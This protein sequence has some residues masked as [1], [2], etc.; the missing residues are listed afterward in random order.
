MLAILAAFAF[1]LAL[2]AIA[3]RSGK[4]FRLTTTGGIAAMGGVSLLTAWW[5]TAWLADAL[6]PR[7]VL[8]LGLATA[9]IVVVGLRDLRRPL[10]PW[11]QLAGQTLAGVSAVLA[12][13]VLA[14]YVTNPL[15]G[16]LYLNQWQVAGLPIVAA[17]LT[18]LWMLLLMN[19]VNFLDGT[20]GVAAAV[21]LVGF[22]TV[23]AVSLLPQV[24]EP[25]TALPAFLAAAATLGFLFWN[26][27]PARLTLGTPGSWF[28]GFLL[29]V[30]SVQGS[31]KIATLAVVGA[32]P[33]LDAISVV[34]ARLRHGVSPFRGDRTHLHH[35]LL[36]RGW[37]P[38]AI[39][40]LYVGISLLL[41]AAAV[42]L[43]TPLKILVFVLS[44][45]TV[46]ALAI[47]PQ[48]LKK[49]G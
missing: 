44:A 39:L 31:S 32:I 24:R 46:A 38:R 11:P 40:A 28:L 41:A 5:I 25:S 37:S 35:R 33:L 14:E 21:S 42:L 43:P 29:A 8:G 13:G 15:G 2:G 27:P 6:G 9:V 26:I 3:R 20:D 19:A 48:I 49:E 12:G 16:L 10:G 36:A 22:L 34:I 45:L 47:R 30:L 4:R 7:A 1:S 23:G 17:A 18:L